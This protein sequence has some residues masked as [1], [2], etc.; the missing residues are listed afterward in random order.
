ME[1]NRQ[2]KDLIK[3]KVVGTINIRK[4]CSFCNNQLKYTQN[5][6]LYIAEGINMITQRINIILLCKECYN[7][8]K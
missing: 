4:F 5:S 1:N 2:M 7:K 6:I 3:I 8:R